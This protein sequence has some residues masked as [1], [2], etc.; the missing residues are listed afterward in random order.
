MVDFYDSKAER[1][2]RNLSLEIQLQP[3][4]FSMESEKIDSE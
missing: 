1:V 3:P 2:L 4:S